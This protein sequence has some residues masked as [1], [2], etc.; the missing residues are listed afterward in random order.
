VRVPG[1]LW[2]RLADE[3]TLD[4]IG[5]NYYTRDFVHNAGFDLAGFLGNGC[6]KDHRLSI[7]AR[8]QLGWEIYPEGLGQLLTEYARYG[9]PILISENGISTRRDT[10]RWLFLYMHLWQ[11]A[12]SISLGVPILG[13]LHWSLLDNFEWAE[14]YAARFGLIEVD[15]KTQERRVRQS[16]IHYRELIRRNRL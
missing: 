1:F 2:E 5:L 9:L 4:F 6:A 12:R 8:N 15:Y 14:G 7:G 11:I 10:A 3:G 13:Y 16:A